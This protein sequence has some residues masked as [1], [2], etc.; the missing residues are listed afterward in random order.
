MKT[1]VNT[2]RSLG[3]FKTSIDKGIYEGNTPHISEWRTTAPNET[4]TLPYQTNGIYNGIIDWGDG[5]Q[6]VNS[7]DNRTHTYA[8]AGS[9]TI[10]ITGRIRI[11]RFNNAGDRT[12]LYIV[13]QWGS[14]FDVGVGGSHFYGCT[15]LN[16]SVVSD[17]LIL[18][19]P[20]V[21]SNIQNF[22]NMFRDCTSLTTINRVDEWDTS[23]INTLQACFFQ[24]S[25]F[26]GNVSSWNVSN[27]TIFQSC[28]GS[29]TNFN[30]N[31]GGWNTISALNMSFMFLNATN[32][33]QP[34]ANW[35]RTT[36][37]ISTLGNVIN[38]QQMFNNAFAFNQN[39]G[40]WNVSNVTNFSSFMAGKTAAN[41]SAANL[42]AI[43]NG[44]I[45]NLLN[46][47]LSI[48]FGTIKYTQAS[49]QG[50]ALLTRTN[51]SLTVSG[52]VNNGSGLIRITTST[53][54]GRVTGNKVFI[55]AV[56][57]TTEANGLWTVTLVNSTQVDLQGST[58]SNAYISGGAFRTGYG[59][60]ITDG[61]LVVSG[62]SNSGG[63]IR[64]TTSVAHGLTT[65]N[66]VFIY[67]VNGTTNAN[68]TWTVTVISTTIIQL[69]GST[70]NGVWTSGGNVILG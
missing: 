61:L 7:Y 51:T 50:K 30:Q 27:V 41:Y 42:D 47:N 69:Q 16:L 21:T 39:I 49:L 11:F 43:Y 37:D 12:K 45:N 2:T 52:A 31:I 4:V 23:N 9:Y 53:A 59:W 26:D 6:S 24:S 65:G 22:A 33:N 1:S 55:S 40:N 48:S 56:T 3:Q 57:G 18:Y 32:F 8:S 29:C 67:G 63:L 46:V 34:L 13:S 68:G 10:K 5:T 44:W 28:F 17:V 36:P 64:V 70:Y 14:Q 54:H 66:S 60:T 62:T 20:F 15:N 19:R 58:F 25:N 35:E 38:M